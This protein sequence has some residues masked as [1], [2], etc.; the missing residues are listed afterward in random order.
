VFVGKD[1]NG[2]IPKII[3]PQEGVKCA[4]ASFK[5]IW[6]YE[7][8]TKKVHKLAKEVVKARWATML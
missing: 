3:H 8:P 1:E 6:E 4:K 5:H 7:K 2:K